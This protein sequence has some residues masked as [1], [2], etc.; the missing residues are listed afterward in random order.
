MPFQFVFGPAGSGK[1]T[2]L[3]KDIIEKSKKFEDQNFIVL[4][5]EQFTMQTQKDLVMLHEAKGIMNIDVLSFVRL[6]YRIFQENGGNRLPILDDEGKNLILRK[7]ALE[8]EDELVILK[9]NVKKLGY[10]SEV[11]SVIS[12]LTQYDV[13]LEK[14]DQLMDSLGQDS[15]LYYKLQDIRIL[16]QRFQDYLR[17][18]YITKEELLDV[19]ARKISQSEII[20]NSTIVLDGFTGFTPV[21][22]RLIGKLMKYSRNVIVSVTMDERENPYKYTHPYQL[23]GLSKQMVA[24][25]IEVAKEQKVEMLETIYLYDSPVFRFRDNP[26][27]G[28]LEKNFFRYGIETFQTEQSSIRIHIARN[29][30]EETKALAQR[31]RMLVRKEG[32]R[33]RDIGVIA[34]NM[35]VYGEDLKRAFE[36]YDIPFFMDHK[37]SILMNPYVEALRGVLR[38]IEQNF[39]YDSVFRVLKTGVFELEECE[40]SNL[41][42]YCLRYGIRGAKK[43]NTQWIR[44]EHKM[45][46][47]ELAKINQTRSFIYEQIEPLY[48]V[49][50]KRKKTVR[51]I[52]ISLYEFMVQ[53]QFEQRLKERESYFT[54][55][56]ELSLAKEHSQIYKII[57][58]LF[59]KFVDLLGEETLKVKE[60]EDIFEAGLVEAK[61][62]I[63]PP[64]VDQIVVGDVER[65][66]LKDVK[67]LLFIGA[68]DSNLPGN[69]MKNGLLSERDREMMG[70][71]KVHLAPGGKERIYI[72]KFYLYLNLTKP[73]KNLDIYYSKVSGAGKSVRESYLIQE[74]KR[75]FPKISVEDE[76]ERTFLEQ[77]NVPESAL[78]HIIKGFEDEKLRESAQW[79]QLYC[80]YC[81]SEK[82]AE[83]LY[84]LRNA[85]VYRRTT[86]SISEEIA[87]KL[88]GEDFQDSISR[89][90]RFSAC[91]FAHFL[92]YGLRLKKRDL[93]EFEAIDFGNICH[94]VLEKYTKELKRR[95]LSWK[96]VSKEQQKEILWD[97]LNEA[98]TDFA[99]QVLYDTTR[100]EAIVSRIYQILCRSVWAMTKQL[101]CGDF[102]TYKSEFRFSN[103]IIDRIDV[104]EDED[105]VYLKV[106]DYKTGNKKFDM[107]SLYH[108]LQLQLMIYMDAAMKIGKREYPGKE[109]IPAGVFYYQMEDP[110]VDGD[111]L[112]EANEEEKA[113]MIDAALLKELRLDGMVNLSKDSLVHFDRKGK[114]ESYAIPIK[115]NANGSLSQYSKVLS[116]EDFQTLLSFA[117]QKVKESH[118]KILKGESQ[119]YPYRKADKTACDYCDYQHI[120]GFDTKMS[121]YQYHEIEK[122]DQQK[123]IQAMREELGE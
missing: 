42:N 95:N 14:L 44:R 101:A 15:R 113:E 47:E 80:W 77:E 48:E 83:K 4:V 13:T 114:G 121:G 110:F 43:W 103:G 38:M 90:E 50:R 12:E 55:I 61:V 37:R 11:K 41:E 54:E 86:D 17:E 36:Q 67:A 8:S 74:L 10:I 53:H 73:S 106:V 117:V 27:M 16:Y 100:N 30:K 29:P 76:E 52:T 45:S 93:F 72:Q 116:E 31:I 118:Q 56:G 57:I 7:L 9:G 64:G 97:C 60:Y 63:I 88:Y 115:Y 91:A 25:L 75:L 108:G 84:E 58:E 22:N 21:Q 39:S 69:L 82:W 18:K 79:K 94:L 78:I 2:Y 99:E 89:I 70:Q 66:R 49:L 85:G 96:E 3:Y 26:E 68:D 104:C 98:V 109:I 112:S 5:P 65:T 87:K 120:C 33:Y 23:F 35:D 24:S 111:K 28:F 102:E 81:T 59:E 19:L 122:M 105:S 40:I 34:S 123:V 71:E 92:T 107:V 1:S 119:I 51:D 32:Y 6:A 62:G 20:K 46:E